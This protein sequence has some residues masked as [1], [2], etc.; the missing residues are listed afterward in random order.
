MEGPQVSVPNPIQPLIAAALAVAFAI[1]FALTR[2]H[3]FADL[4]G[5][6]TTYALGGI[7]L[8]RTGA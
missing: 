5:L 3:F 1:I 7:S 8:R 4:T 6:A 2:D